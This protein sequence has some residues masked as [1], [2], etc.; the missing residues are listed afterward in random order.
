MEHVHPDIVML[1]L[2]ANRSH[3]LTMDEEN[4]KKQL[5]D[6]NITSIIRQVGNGQCRNQK[7]LNIL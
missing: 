4:I 5:K 6:I 2:C 3:T 7:R 1:E